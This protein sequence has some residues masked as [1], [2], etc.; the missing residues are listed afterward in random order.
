MKERTDSQLML[1]L[2][3]CLTSTETVRLIRD[4]TGEPRTA[5]PAFTQL[6][7]Y[8]FIISEGAGGRTVSPFKRVSQG[9]QTTTS[10]PAMTLN[11]FLQPFLARP[12][13]RSRRLAC[14]ALIRHAIFV[15]AEGFL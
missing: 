7:T 2:K 4:G 3:C 14:S 8:V 5:T 15:T 12:A 6:L 11:T 9:P 1:W 13:R 10:S